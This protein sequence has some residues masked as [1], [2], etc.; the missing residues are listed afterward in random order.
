[1]ENIVKNITILQWNGILYRI[2]KKLLTTCA[3]VA[4][5]AFSACGTSATDT[6]V[7]TDADGIA[8]DIDNCPNDPNPEQVNSDKADDGGDACDPDD[9]NDEVLD[10]IDNC[11][12]LPNRN[13]RNLDQDDD[14]DLCD[15]DVDGDGIDNKEDSDDDGDGIE[16]TNPSGDPLDN[17]Q[18]VPNAPDNQGDPQDNLDGDDYGDA[19]D[20][21][22]DGRWNL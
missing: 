18:Y 5:L 14:G 3:M 13:Q 19:C 12:Y 2:C 11:Q 20:D 22:I 4:L 9:D 8:D 10:G 6:P 7:D 16:D 17:C 15:S 1:M 21:D